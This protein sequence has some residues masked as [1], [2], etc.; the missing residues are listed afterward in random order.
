MTVGVLSDSF[1]CYAVYAVPGSG[2]PVSGNEGYA[3]NGFT[4]DYATDVSTGALP[5][6]VNVLAEP[7][8]RYHRPP[9]T[10]WHYGAPTQTA[11]QR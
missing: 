10:A 8:T 6:G 2:V 9:A 7:F 4:A 3:Y 5:A 1:N 11:V